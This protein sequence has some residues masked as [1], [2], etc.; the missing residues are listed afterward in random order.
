M[1]N[2]RLGSGLDVPRRWRMRRRVVSWLR[3][4]DRC[5]HCGAAGYVAHE[6]CS[7]CGWR[8]LGSWTLQPVRCLRIDYPY[9]VWVTIS[10]RV[11]NDELTEL[12]SGCPGVD[13]LDTH[14]LV[15]TPPWFPVQ[16]QH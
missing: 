15:S 3:L 12:L 2:S 10:C 16:R 13:L 1:P 14:S 5:R 4:H 9:S 7:C 11:E 8:H 6:E